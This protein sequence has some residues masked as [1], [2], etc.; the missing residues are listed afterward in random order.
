MY[1]NVTYFRTRGRP[2][3]IEGSVLLNR[4]GQKYSYTLPGSLNNSGPL[5][6]T[7]SSPGTLSVPGFK[8][9]PN[10]IFFVLMIICFNDNIV[11]MII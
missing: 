8:A 2:I 7:I 10:E 1:R 5:Y 4:T 3:S 11:L 9:D 6:G